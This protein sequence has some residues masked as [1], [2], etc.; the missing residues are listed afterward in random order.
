MKIPIKTQ[1]ELFLMRK[2][3]KITA[4]I[5]AEL[6]DIIKPGISTEAIDLYVNRRM[7]DFKAIPATLNYHGF[8]K[9][10]CTSINEVICHGIPSSSEI[11]KEGDI[12]NVD[13]TSISEGYYGDSSRMYFVGGRE[14]CSPEAQKLVDITYEALMVGIRQVAPRKKFSDIGN[15]IQKFIENETV[16]YGIVRDYTGHGIGSSFHEPPQILHVKTF[17]HGIFMMPGMCFTIEPMINLGT[18]KT[19]LNTSDG[20]TVKTADGKLSAQWEH[21]IAVTESG[22]EILTKV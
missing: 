12:I 9:S 6:E 4:Q 15:A 19:V 18:H 21:T 17:S 3:G 16:K 20:W 10:C 5:L 13:I 22:Y 7:S 8:P 1:Q 14:A 2:A 11:L